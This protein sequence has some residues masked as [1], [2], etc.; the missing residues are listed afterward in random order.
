MTPSASAFAS[1]FASTT[2]TNGAAAACAPPPPACASDA[3]TRSVLGLRLGAA[4]CGVDLGCVQEIRAFE[5]PTR[6]AHAAACV[7]GV[8]NLRGAIVP[9]V[10]VRA[11]VDGAAADAA[12]AVVVVLA[13]GRRLLGLAAD[14]ATEVLELDPARLQPPGVAGEVLAG[15]ALPLVQAQAPVGD[16]LLQLLD[17]A[18][19]LAALDGDPAPPLQ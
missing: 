17:P 3:A 11:R 10:D 13:I 16:R 5:R 9:I 19:L 4:L 6:L 8:V 12:P 14:A 7:L 18:A 2:T 15:D 1:A